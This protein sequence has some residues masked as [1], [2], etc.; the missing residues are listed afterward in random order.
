[1]IKKTVT[2]ERTQNPSGGLNCTRAGSVYLSETP[3]QSSCWGGHT[4]V[5]LC[6]QSSYPHTRR[7]TAKSC[8]PH[9]PRVTLLNLERAVSCPRKKHQGDAHVLILWLHAENRDISGLDLA[10]DEVVSAPAE[11]SSA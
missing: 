5:P 1:M 6:R 10:R 11:G 3:A 4:L 2:Q 7:R 9:F 8:P